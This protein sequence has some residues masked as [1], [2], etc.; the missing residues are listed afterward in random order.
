MKVFERYIFRLKLLK[1]V[2][3][4]HEEEF[5]LFYWNLLFIHFGQEFIVFGF[6]FSTC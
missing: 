2:S 5:S 4:I 3:L 6:P 1:M